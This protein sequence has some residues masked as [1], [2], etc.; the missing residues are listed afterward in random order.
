[1]E[2]GEAGGGRQRQV[3]TTGISWIYVGRQ[4][5]MMACPQ[6]AP[7]SAYSNSWPHSFTGRWNRSQ[8]RRLVCASPNRDREIG[9]R[10]KDL[11]ITGETVAAARALSKACGCGSVLPRRPAQSRYMSRHR[12]RRPRHSSL[13]CRFLAN[14][15]AQMPLTQSAKG[16]TPWSVVIGNRIADSL[17]EPGILRSV[18]CLPR[19]SGASS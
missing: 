7:V 13:Q 15:S 14:R 12:T 5:G 8:T 11:A 9:T 10:R 3:S 19:W 18:K 16:N 1:M 2:S 6:S 17:V 4:K